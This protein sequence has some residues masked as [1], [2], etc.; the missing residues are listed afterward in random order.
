MRLLIID[1]SVRN[2]KASSRVAKWVE[3]IARQ[4]LKDIAIEAIDLKEL[5]LPM[6]DEAI[7]PMANSDR[8]PEGGTKTWLDALAGADAYVFV[9]PE[10]NHAVPSGLKN[11]IDYI[12]FQVMHKPFLVVSHG[13]N[14]GARAAEQLKQTLNANIGAIPLS[15]GL[16]INGMIGH[17]DMI[18]EA[19]VSNVDVVSKQEKGLE[20]KLALLVKYA[21]ALKSLRD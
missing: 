3:I 6:F 2:A 7:L 16:T 21:T 13:V 8:K 10:Y 15:G 14:G 18:S 20:D 1:G 12:N 9:T 11:A 5:N 4:S 17:A 19:G